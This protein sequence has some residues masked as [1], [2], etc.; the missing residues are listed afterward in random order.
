MQWSPGSRIP[1]ISVWIYAMHPQFVTC[2]NTLDCIVDE[3][4]K[5]WWE[6]ERKGGGG[7]TDQTFSSIE[8][9]MYVRNIFR[10]LAMV[11]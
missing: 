1:T 2:N 4:E 3:V 11:P 10:H 9:L 6:R 5:A 8:N 7:K